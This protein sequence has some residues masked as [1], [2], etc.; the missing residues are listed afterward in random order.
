MSNVSKLSK[1]RGQS[2]GSLEK[3]AG[4]VRLAQSR[5]GAKS[6]Q[7]PGSLCH[8]ESNMVRDRG[9]EPLTPSVSRKCS[10][11]ELTAQAAKAGGYSRKLAQLGKCRF[12]V[13]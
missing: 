11:T 10:T 8:S 5:G 13:S 7:G 2:A 12:L 1:G 4:C 6:S 3:M 9:F